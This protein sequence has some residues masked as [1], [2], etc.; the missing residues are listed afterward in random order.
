MNKGIKKFYIGI[1]SSKQ[2]YNLAAI[3]PTIKH[4]GLIKMVSKDYQ[5]VSFDTI[6]EIKC[7]YKNLM[8]A[9]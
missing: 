3:H 8:K 2:K 1:D 7:I 4:L 5:Y 6:Y 9:Y